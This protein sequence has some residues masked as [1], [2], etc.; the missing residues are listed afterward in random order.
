MRILFWGVFLSVN[1]NF[2]YD[3]S[4]IWHHKSWFSENH[5][6]LAYQ[7][8][9]LYHEKRIINKAGH[10]SW[11]FR[12]SYFGMTWKTDYWT[13]AWP[14]DIGFRINNNKQLDICADHLTL[15]WPSD[16]WVLWMYN[17]IYFSQS[18]CLHFSY[19]AASYE[20]KPI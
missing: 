17:C 9:I 8:I 15:A 6:M 2:T 10:Q 4:I 19:W 11:A 3:V 20:F 13:F 1:S 5:G 14:S 7:A 16:F 12:L 18:L